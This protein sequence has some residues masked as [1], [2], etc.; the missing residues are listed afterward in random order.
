MTKA[1]RTPLRYGIFLLIGL[2]L[3]EFA[4]AQ[5]NVVRRPGSRPDLIHFGDV[6][7]VDVVGSLEFDWRGGLTPEGF[8]KAMTI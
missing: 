1:Y 6:I 8:S 3:T 2:V 5:N 7:D 4:V